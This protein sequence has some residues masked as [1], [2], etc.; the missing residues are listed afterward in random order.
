MPTEQREISRKALSGEAMRAIPVEEV[1]SV[2][3][4]IVRRR[5]AF[6][7]CDPAGIVYTPRFF[8]PI[9]T[10]ALDL[11]FLEAFG[12]ERAMDEGLEHVGTP[13][14]AVEFVFHK[15]SPLHALI[16]IEIHCEKIGTKTFVVAMEARN[17]ESEALF[18][19]RL[20]IICVNRDGFTSIPVPELMKQKLGR[21]MREGL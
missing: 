11:F 12:F 8:D 18:S 2:N 19:A 5:I 3:P 16:D 21:Y 1:V 7:D 10:G 14:K 15:P 6:R 9:A 4:F 20:T 13:A 17:A